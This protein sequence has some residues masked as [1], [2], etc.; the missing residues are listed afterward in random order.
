MSGIGK[1]PFVNSTEDKL[2]FESLTVGQIGEKTFELRNYSLVQACYQFEKIND[3]GTDLS[4][5]LSESCGT[6]LPGK[7]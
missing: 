5:S 4:F 6:I 1:F 3:D 7:S 2:N